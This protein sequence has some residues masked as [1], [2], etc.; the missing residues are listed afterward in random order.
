MK[1][2]YNHI[3]SFVRDAVVSGRFKP[4]DK[5]PTDYELAKEYGTSRLTVH[6]A[7]RELADE[8]VVRREPRMGTIVSD[9]SRH[10]V[11]SVA[12]LLP[13]EMSFR[14]SQW[15]SELSGDLLKQG[16]SL[17]PYDCRSVERAV[18]VAQLLV[19]NRVLGAVLAPP[20]YED[21]LEIIDVFRRGHIP[22]I[23]EGKFDLPNEAISY[24]STNH[25]QGGRLLGEHLAS[26]G[27]RRL[28]A[29]TSSHTQDV[30]ER[31]GG[32][33]EGLATQGTSLAKESV[34]EIRRFNEMPYAV[35][36]LMNR[37]DRP[38]AILG[39]N[40]YVAMEVMVALI[41]QG[42]SVPNDC[43]IVG[44]GDE[45]MCKALLSPMTTVRAPMEEEGRLLASVMLNT[46]AGRLTEPQRIE[47]DYELVVRRSCGFGV[48]GK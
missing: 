9:P 10:V 23:V 28:A 24:V 39:I 44:M 31:L 7:L 26:V 36:E 14:A 19:R 33:R 46:I 15:V 47:L 37:A 27:H 32:F 21:S 5:L 48:F 8:G 30:L 43:A 13:A 4:N 3:K 18:Q 35:R 16:I 17:V 20:T 38:T 22:V 6:R 40:D 34:F 1:I 29:I 11:G 25:R 41:D 45:P 42:Y 2:T 12:L